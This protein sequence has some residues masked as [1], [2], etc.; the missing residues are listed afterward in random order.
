M[1]SLNTPRLWKRFAALLFDGTLTLI[2]ALVC[3]LI[4]SS[5]VKT[6]E[7]DAAIADAY[8]RFGQEYGVNFNI[9]QEEYALLTEEEI[10]RY[11][12]AY[13]AMGE[14]PAVISAYEDILRLSL[15]TIALAIL[16][17][18]LFLELLVPLVLG[19][20]QTLG[21]RII[22]LGVVQKNGD[23]VAPLQLTV[24][25][26][27][28][29]YTIETLVPV[30][31]LLM[32]ALGVLGLAVALLVVAAQILLLCTSKDRAVIHD[33]ISSTVCVEVH[34]ITNRKTRTDMYTPK[35]HRVFRNTL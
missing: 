15:L 12:E 20:G 9:S 32:S 11:D 33:R 8:D 30:L 18:F 24:R 7:A 25:T 19:N 13:A 5:M 31:F 22:G 28:G 23:A 2:I 21:K 1:N 6:P 16:V 4:F 10:A 29:K 3:S 14:D 27:V 34:S 35:N 17:P 26:I